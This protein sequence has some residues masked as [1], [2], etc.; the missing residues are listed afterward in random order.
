[1]TTLLPPTVT[2]R[3]AF[4]NTSAAVVGTLALG[5]LAPAQAAAVPETDVL[6]R[7]LHPYPNK[8]TWGTGT[9]NLARNVKL[10]VGGDSDPALVQMLQ[11][12]W[13]RFTFGTVELAVTR[14]ASLT[15]G[16][17]T[18]SGARP[19]QRQPKATYSLKVDAAGIAASATDAAGVRHAWFTLLQLLEADE[20]AAGGGPVFTLPQVEI[21]DWPA[22]KFRGLHLCIFHETSPLMIEKAIRLAAFFK[23]THVVLEFWGMLRLDAMRELSWPEAWPKAEAGRLIGIARNMGLEVVPM[24][25]CW[26]HA[27][28]CRIK[29]GRHVVLD[30]NPRLAPLFEPDGWTW[31][32]TNP[33]TQDLLRRV[34]DEL[35]EF[36]GPGQFF[37]IGCDEAYSHATCDR[38]RQ[39][40]RVQLF[41]D[42]INNLAAHLE[43]RGRRAIMWG[44][45]LL[46]SGKWPAGF[47]AN[48]SPAL[49]THE[50]LDRVS[51]KI[52]IADWHYDV[53]KGEVPTLAHFHGRGFETLA[54]P[55]NSPS[56][57]R[58]LAKAASANQ[59][60]LLM[61][62]WH[63]L[64]QSIP[65]LAYTANCA[66]SQ[67]QTALG[68]R[69]MDWSLMRAA[70]AAVLRKLVP[71]DGKF[72]RAGWNSFELPAEAD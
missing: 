68:M 21:H 40:D 9:F 66:W 65:T 70:T 7:S 51:R 52:M 43:K 61:T 60:G 35:I 30:Q 38:C 26:G 55:W 33:R 42:H 20:S 15:A 54:C 63:H 1:M 17:F 31:C 29:H 18:L 64:V 46:E 25:N 56:N 37:H 71:A 23:F 6:P 8:I 28:A 24:F 58:T 16:Q 13:Q 69:Q 19:P 59:S 2:S 57:I 53:T 48:G 22:L 41:A 72:E 36:A 50:A 32:L 11:E 14:D 67:D 4:L 39:A 3:R 47:A 44:D 34:C 45:A 12:T 62:T 49:P 10:A 5:R 27:T